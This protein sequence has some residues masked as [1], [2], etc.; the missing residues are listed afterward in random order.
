MEMSSGTTAN[1]R[2]TWV[3]PHAKV[4]YDISRHA[5]ALF[6]QAMAEHE[7]YFSAIADSIPVGYYF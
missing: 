6:L 3:A 7:G 4:S 2:R 1:Y 5:M